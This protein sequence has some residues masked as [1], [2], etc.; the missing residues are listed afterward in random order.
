MDDWHIVISYIPKII[1]PNFIYNLHTNIIIHT[2]IF[3][4]RNSAKLRLTNLGTDMK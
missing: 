3:V 4:T 2:S 1:T